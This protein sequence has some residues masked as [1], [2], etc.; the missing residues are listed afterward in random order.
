MHRSVYGVNY[1]RIGENREH[2]GRFLLIGGQN[3]PGQSEILP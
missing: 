2:E 3:G 1:M